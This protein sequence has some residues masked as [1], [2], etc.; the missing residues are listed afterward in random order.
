MPSC[1]HIKIAILWCYYTDDFISATVMHSV[2]KMLIWKEIRLQT[3]NMHAH[4]SLL[5]ISTPN[6]SPLVI[7]QSTRKNKV[8]RL[9][10]SNTQSHTDPYNGTTFCCSVLFKS[11]TPCWC[12]LFTGRKVLLP[13]RTYRTSRHNELYRSDYRLLR[14]RH[15]PF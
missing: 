4:H 6:P 2:F 3:C 12:H 14:K 9:V 7:F 8:L 10:R 11:F 13:W 5:Q 1:K 15:C